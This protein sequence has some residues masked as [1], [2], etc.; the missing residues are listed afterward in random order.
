MRLLACKFGVGFTGW[1]AQHGEPILVNDANADPARGDDRGDRRRRR[2]DAGRADALRRIDHRRDHP[3]EARVR[4]VRRRR[5]A[6]PDDPRRPGGDRGRVG[7]VADPHPGP[8]PRDAPS[9][10][11]ER[12][13]VGQPRPAPGR[14]PDGRPPR[15]R[16]GRRRMHHQLLGSSG[17]MVDSLGLL[18]AGPPRRHRA[19]PTRSRL[20]GD[21]A[22][23]RRPG[24]GDRRR[25][26]SGSR[27]GGSRADAGRWQQGARD[28]ATRRQGP[29][30]RARRADLGRAGRLGRRAPRPR[31]DDGQRGGD[32]ARE[33]P[34]VRGRPRSSPTAIR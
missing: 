5:S 20:P 17:G 26:R 29:V 18:P 6:G 15:D 9:P 11:H 4:R 21:A 19:V 2:V 32:G 13:A 27:P 22:R 33:C 34:A 23:P 1:V 12:R 28:A 25:R 30:D 10:R 31:P 24:R 14:R 16:D 3:V 8:R 7:P